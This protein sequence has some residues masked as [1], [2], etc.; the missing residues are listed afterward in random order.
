MYKV[1]T[2]RLIIVNGLMEAMDG[3]CVHGWLRVKITDLLSLVKTFLF[4]D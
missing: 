4:L 2:P 1:L 3:L